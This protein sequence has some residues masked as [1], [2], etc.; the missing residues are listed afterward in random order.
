[1]VIPGLFTAYGIAPL[2]FN[3]PYLA[4]SIKVRESMEI[5]FEGLFPGF[6]T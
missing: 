6:S 4:I 1:M 2:K 5:Y 3:A